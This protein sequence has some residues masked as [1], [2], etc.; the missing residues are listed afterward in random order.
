MFSAKQVPQYRPP[1][2]VIWESFGAGRNRKL[3][4]VNKKEVILYE[5][6]NSKKVVEEYVEEKGPSGN[7]I[8]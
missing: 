7:G 4:T 5:E 8:N 6:M 1:L 2:K 3:S